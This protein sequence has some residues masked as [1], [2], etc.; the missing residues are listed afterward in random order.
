MNLRYEKAP[1]IDV[2]HVFSKEGWGEDR[3]ATFVQ[4]GRDSKGRIENAAWMDRHYLFIP[5]AN[6]RLFNL[7][8]V[9]FIQETLTQLNRKV[10]K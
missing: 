1:E 7:E 4:G 6:H 10:S 8:E 5:S 9:T 2:Y 3:I